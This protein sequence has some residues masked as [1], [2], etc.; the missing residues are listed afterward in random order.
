M[1]VSG[2]PTNYAL[3]CKSV[4][5]EWGGAFLAL[6]PSAPPE[7]PGVK[8]A[9]IVQSR[10]VLAVTYLEQGKALGFVPRS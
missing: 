3:W 1:D 2:K 10:Y 5:P 9:F 6:T 4:H 7:Q 8:N